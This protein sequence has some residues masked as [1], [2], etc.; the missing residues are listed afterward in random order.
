MGTRFKR[1][2]GSR[3]IDS[4]FTNI[5]LEENIN[6]CTNLLFDNED[7]IEGIKRSPL[8]PNIANAFLSFHEFTW[9]EQCPKEFKGA[10]SGLRQFLA[11]ESPLRMMKNAFYLTSKAL[12]FLKT[13]NFLS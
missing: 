8:G 2:V 10:L 7:I 1:F 12:F 11:T 13:F 9:L 6:I 4:L 5:P 3:N